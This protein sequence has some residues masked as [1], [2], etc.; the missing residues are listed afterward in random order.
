[1]TLLC[2]GGE[3]K[4]LLIWDVE[5]KKEAQK[6]DCFEAPITCTA[7][8]PLEQCVLASTAQKTISMFDLRT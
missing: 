2:S 1:M 5:K 6:Y 3:D 8:H 7:F 4:K